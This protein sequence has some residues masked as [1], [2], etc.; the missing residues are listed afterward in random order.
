MVAARKPLSSLSYFTHY[1]TIITSWKCTVA[2]EFICEMIAY[3]AERRAD[4]SQFFFISY[5]LVFIQHTSR[6]LL[7][8]LH[9]FQFSISIVAN[10]KRFYFHTHMMSVFIS[11]CVCVCAVNS[12]I[13]TLRSHLPIFYIRWIFATNHKVRLHEIFQK[14]KIQISIH[15]YEI[16]NQNN[17]IQ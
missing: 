4:P 5:W 7:Y 1:S 12:I 14:R 3:S 13:R 11:V 2:D 17:S 16:W 10:E 6:I 9:R 8:P 15:F